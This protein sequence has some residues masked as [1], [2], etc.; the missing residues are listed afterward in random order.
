MKQSDIVQKVAE[1]ITSVEPQISLSSIK[2][3]STIADLGITS[4]Q[5]IEIGVLL[6]DEFGSNVGLDEWLEQE[7]GKESNAFSIHSLV[8]FIEKAA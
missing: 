5:L 8:A 1:V 6:E 7:R 4:L 3:E 2:I